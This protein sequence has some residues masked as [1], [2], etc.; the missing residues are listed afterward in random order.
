[1][2]NHQRMV[3]V[4]IHVSPTNSPV[5]VGVYEDYQDAQDKQEEQPEQFAVFLAPLF[6]APPLEP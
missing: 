5:V 6:L 2:N 4:V 3:F 1:V